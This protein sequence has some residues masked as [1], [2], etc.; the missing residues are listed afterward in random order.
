MKIIAW[1][2]ETTHNIIAA[3]DLYNPNP[4]ANILQEKYIISAS[5]TEIGSGKIRSVSV[6]DDPAGTDATV[7]A[8][9][10]E[11][12]NTADAVVAHYGDKFDMRFFMSRVIYWGFNPPPPV[13]QIDTY[14]IAK[15]KFKFN[16][17]KLDY[18]GKFLG[19]GEKKKTENGLWLRC[20]AGDTKAIKEMIV[21]NKQD[22][23]LL[24]DVYNKLAPF[25]P[26]RMNRNLHSTVPCCPLC[27]ENKLQHRG[28]RKTIT[29]EYVRYQCQSCG[30]WSSS[31]NA[32]KTVEV[33]Q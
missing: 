27:G 12:F 13:I 30:K 19:V 21:Y 4:V 32:I 18:L 17:N 9:L 24:V 20:L 16:S 2:I 8:D 11:V 5:W 31:T 23:Q 14:K 10:L 26:A 15:S 25:V 7:V 6:L 29:R 22:V 28:T 1:D 3:F 33:A